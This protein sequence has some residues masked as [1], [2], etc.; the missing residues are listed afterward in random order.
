MLSERDLGRVFKFISNPNEPFGKTGSFLVD[1]CSES[2]ARIIDEY[3]QRLDA[4][5]IDDCDDK[6]AK[7]KKACNGDEKHWSL[8]ERELCQLAEKIDVVTK[9]IS[10]LSGRALSLISSVDYFRNSCGPEDY[11][12]YGSV[13]NNINL[14]DCDIPYIS[15]VNTSRSDSNTEFDD[16]DIMNVAKC[17]N[18]RFDE[19]CKLSQVIKLVSGV[20]ASNKTTRLKQLFHRIKA[21]NQCVEWLVEKILNHLYLASY[22]G[23]MLPI[24]HALIIAQAIH[25]ALSSKD[26]KHV[27]YSEWGKRAYSRVV[28]RYVQMHGPRY[29]VDSG[30]VIA[31]L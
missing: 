30:D 7:K 4:C 2:L 13:I 3:I 1:H 19:L 11:H 27:L 24:T 21:E 14:I 25:D 6:S 31:E 28:E 29:S 5:E 18:S 26:S 20:A 16:I 12:V 22:N 23:K 17:E 10:S 15:Y 9:S 8:V